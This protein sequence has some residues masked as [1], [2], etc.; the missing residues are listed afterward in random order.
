MIIFA[1]S[2]Y[3]TNLIIANVETPSQDD[4]YTL[5]AF[6][7]MVMSLGGGIAPARVWIRHTLLEAKRIKNGFRGCND[8]FLL[9]VLCQVRY[10]GRL[11]GG[12]SQDLRQQ[13]HN[14]SG[15]S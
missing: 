8:I 13:I 9:S 4:S 1:G 12:I 14:R 10:N 5:T 3:A 2:E 6:L 11:L 7:Q 15:A